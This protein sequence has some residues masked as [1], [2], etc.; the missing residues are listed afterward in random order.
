MKTSTWHKRLGHPYEEVLSAMVKASKVSVSIDSSKSVCSF[1]V[2]NKM[3]RQSFVVRQSS[4]GFMF[5]KLP[6]DVWGPSLKISI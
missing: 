4:A 6:L 3:C 2:Q 1:C 5:Q